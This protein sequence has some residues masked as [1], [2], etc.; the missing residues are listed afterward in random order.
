MLASNIPDLLQ[1]PICRRESSRDGQRYINHV[2]RGSTVHL[3]IRETKQGTPP[4]LYA[5]P[6]TYREHQDEQPNPVRSSI[7]SCLGKGQ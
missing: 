1:L 5:G 6:M 3:F 7:C 2:E 4:Y